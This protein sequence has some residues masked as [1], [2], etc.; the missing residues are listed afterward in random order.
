MIPDPDAQM[1]QPA[2]NGGAGEA[3]GQRPIMNNKDIAAHTPM[4]QQYLRIKAQHPDILMFYRMGDFYE[5]F[6]D[7]A[8]KAA[9]LLDITLTRRGTSGGEPIKMAG[10]PY[11]SADQYLAK[12]VR[13]GESVVICEQ[14]GDPAT[15]KGPVERQVTRIV[16]PGTLTDAALLE[17]KRESVIVALQVHESVLGLAWLNLA[18]GKFCVMETAPDNLAAELERLKPAEVLIPD[19]PE[20]LDG[21]DGDSVFRK[22][23]LKRLPFWQFDVEAAARILSRQFGTHD[24]SG[25]GC[26]SLRP[27][28][29]AAGAL[30]EYVRLTQGT[31]IA[32]ISALGVEQDGAYLRLDAATR[33]NLEISE[34]ILG[35][36]AP[37]LLSLLD[38]CSTNM[39]SRL[40]RHWLHH[41]LRD[42]ALIQNRLDSVSWLMGEAGSG[43]YLAVR[44][45]LKRVGD[46]ERI[47]ARVA[48]KSARPR[49]LSGL[50]DSLK[51]LPQALALI[52]E[53]RSAN[54]EPINTS[55]A[56]LAKKMVPDE[57]LIALLEKA[58]RDEPAVMLREGGV[59]ADGYDA[60]LDELRAIQNNCG[61][62]LLRL[63][64]REKTRTGI[65]SLKV[66][67]NRLHGFY[68]E[69][70]HA[71][72]DK[73]PSDY[74]RRQTLKNAERYITPE[75]KVF[76]D[77]A[78]SAQ[79]HALDREKFLYGELLDTLAP[80]VAHLQG[81]AQSVA[82]LDVLA[83]FAERALALD[84]TL[85]LFIDETAIEIEAGRHPVVER[86][87]EN[88]IANDLRLG[89]CRGDQTRQM[90]VITGPNMGGKSTYMRQ[91]ALIAL[92]AHCGSFVPAASARFGPLDQI[93]TRIGAS[94]DLAGGRS[95]FMLEMNEAANI[96]HNASSQSLVLMDEVGRGTSTFDGLAL[97]LAIARYLLEKNGSYTLFATHYF[98]LTQ[99][100]EEFPQ[101][102][103]VHLRAV[104]HKHRIVFLHAINDGPASQSYGLQ[105]AALAGVPTPVIKTARQYL[106]K[107]EK[108]AV[109]RHPQLDLFSD[110]APARCETGETAET[111][112]SGEILAQH[113]VFSMLRAVIPDELSPKQA[114]DTLYALKDAAEKKSP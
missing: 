6:F 77:K 100:A 15:A 32:H 90:L 55:I 43:P 20:S 49:D 38:T 24:L 44:A 85:P 57:M 74:R 68:I 34:T 72:S 110:A 83:T 40:L 28:L 7:D 41:P 27:S 104:E 73:V 12:L 62:F 26:E 67:Y 109:G 2:E 103:N 39:G 45:C 42:R 71:H 75:L 53:M 113:P 58:L 114:L 16:T 88:F 97:A 4:M 99:L 79:G 98:E 48:L 105:V 35:D 107:L 96:L 70:T 8:E 84:Y 5:L 22:T 54:S 13:L 10:V 93:F 56:V 64:E 106:V 112:Q 18:G 21:L 91:A 87:V 92:L 50:R 25:F 29:G 69:V 30:L 94:D 76:E 78:L 33:R 9:R 3:P 19:S 11:H 46:I 81:V 37:T 101:V 80:Y 59:I 60:E 65:P 51:Q 52:A 89:A 61:E 23:Y 36:A 66:E 102:A 82:E 111:W 63:E 86:Q 17:E 14:T 1:S 47:T 95:T 108:E 31:S